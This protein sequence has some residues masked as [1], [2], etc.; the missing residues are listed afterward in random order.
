MIF[1]IVSGSGK[2]FFTMFEAVVN[3]DVSRDVYTTFEIIGNTSWDIQYGMVIVIFF[4]L[5]IAVMFMNMLISIIMGHYGEIREYKENQYLV[6]PKEAEGYVEVYT[7]LKERGRNLFKPKKKAEP[8]HH[9]VLT[10]T[11]KKNIRSVSSK[12]ISRF[13]EIPGDVEA[14]PASART[15]PAHDTGGYDSE[16]E[17]SCVPN[18]NDDETSCV[19]SFDARANTRY[20]RTP[21]V[22]KTQTHRSIRLIRLLRLGLSYWGCRH[23]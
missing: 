7:G 4:R 2:A 5:F 10:P 23:I 3:G 19:P 18:S 22:C 12:S 9:K 11:S 13:K 16:R 17:L 6:N 20:S 21:H 15:S 1:S 14:A 8:E